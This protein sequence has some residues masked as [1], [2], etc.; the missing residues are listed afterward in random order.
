MGREGQE[1]GAEGC[2][3]GRR[4]SCRKEA[5]ETAGLASGVVVVVV[6]GGIL[7]FG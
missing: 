1:L 5:V 7:G 3:F 4:K 6:R 2:D